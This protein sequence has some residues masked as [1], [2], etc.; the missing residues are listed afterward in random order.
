MG[1]MGTVFELVPKLKSALARFKNASVLCPDVGYRLS[2]EE[3]ERLL[4]QLDPGNTGRCKL[5][6][7]NWS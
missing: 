7:Y 2:P 4:D 6:F 1:S 3:L 5:Q